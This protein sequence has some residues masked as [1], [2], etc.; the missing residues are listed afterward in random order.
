MLGTLLYT[1]LV[2]PPD[3][4]GVSHHFLGAIASTL[5]LEEIS[6]HFGRARSF[7]RIKKSAKLQQNI[8]QPK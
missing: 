3:V 5:T 7:I 2:I 8:T 1:N 6:D 4:F